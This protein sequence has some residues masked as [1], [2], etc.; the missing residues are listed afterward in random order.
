MACRSLLF[1]SVAAVTAVFA[2]PR[3]DIL[4][5]WQLLPLR[6][7]VSL[8]FASILLTEVG[9]FSTV[10][11]NRNPIALS[12]EWTGGYMGRECLTV[13]VAFALGLH[14]TGFDG[15]HSLFNL[16]LAGAAH[17]DAHQLLLTHTQSD[18]RSH[19]WRRPIRSVAHVNGCACRLPDGVDVAASTPD[20]PAHHGLVYLQPAL[21]DAAAT[22]PS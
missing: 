18:Y 8:R 1:W 11:S 9:K 19:A 14:N 12:A 13:A 2:A 10:C 21:G 22:T 6:L 7:L 17:P 16:L 20:Q 5:F 3:Q 15:A 4:G